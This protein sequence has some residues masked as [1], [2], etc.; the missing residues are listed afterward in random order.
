MEANNRQSPPLTLP[1]YRYKPVQQKKNHTSAH[2]CM[3]RDAFFF[4]K[5]ET[6]DLGI[7]LQG[8]VLAVPKDPAIGEPG[9]KSFYSI[10]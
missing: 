9:T 1:P 6:A 4:R 2:V 8:R 10:T 3:Q 5:S 7:P